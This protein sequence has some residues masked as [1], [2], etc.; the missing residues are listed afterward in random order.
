MFEYLQRFGLP[1]LGVD[2]PR[3]YQD[4]PFPQLG[5]PAPDVVE[6]RYGVLI[7]EDPARA[8]AKGLYA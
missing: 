7:D 3:R 4:E 8:F 1:F 2:Y 6:R 5:D